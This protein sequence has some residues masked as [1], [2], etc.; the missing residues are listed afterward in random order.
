MNQQQIVQV[1]INKIEQE[2]MNAYSERASHQAKVT[3]ASAPTGNAEADKRLQEQAAIAV[4][5]LAM[6]ARMIDTREATLA[7]LN[8]QMATLNVASPST[9]PQP[10][11]AS[12]GA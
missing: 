8:D 7:A 6:L 9:A 4:N 10:K 1:Q 5:T 2:I 11:P 3:D 12:L